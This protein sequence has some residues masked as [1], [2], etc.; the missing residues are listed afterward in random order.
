MNIYVKPNGI[1]KDLVHILEELYP[2]KIQSRMML[3]ISTEDKK[4][5]T[6][7]KA[8]DIDTEDEMNAAPMKV[9]RRKQQRVMQTDPTV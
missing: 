3:E 1:M 9:K 4:I 7:L 6:L 5:G 8:V 2:G